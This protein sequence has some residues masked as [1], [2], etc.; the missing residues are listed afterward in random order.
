MKLLYLTWEFP[1]LITGGLGMAC[2]GMVKELLSQGTE[3]DLVL[4]TKEASYFSLKKPEDVDNL[5]SCY[6]NLVHPEKHPKSSSELME[7]IK[8]SFGP[9]ASPAKSKKLKIQKIQKSADI[10]ELMDT[11]N[12]ESSLFQQVRG[13][14]RMAIDVGQRLDYDIIHAHDWLAYP[15]GIL[16]KE[17]TQKPMVAHIHATEFD[18]SGGPGSHRI[19]NIEY[20]GMMAADKVVAVSNLTADLIKE[21]YHI[22]AD[23]I[24][25]VHNAF[26]ITEAPE[27]KK[28]IFKEPMVLFM[29]RITIQKGPDYFLEVAR[30]VLQQNRNVRFVMAGSGDMERHI[31]HKAASMGM[32]TRFLFSG[33]LKRNEVE[34]VLSSADIFMLPSV[35]EPFGIAPL[36]A[37]SYGALAVISKNAGV[38]EI[39]QNAYKIDFWDIDKM[40]NVVLDF[41]ND[42]A[43]FREASIKSR[44]EVMNMKWTEAVKKLTNVFYE[45]EELKKC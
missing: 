12:D 7:L 26:T 10:A 36:E 3:I 16:L 5:A 9:Y 25:I 42:P 44:Q 45:V 2:Y 15:A 41:V 14:T 37:M 19:H 33:F 31:L 22:P 23:R 13:Y 4:P 38:A 35:S 27:E 34:K 29:G 28:K 8:P 18:R 24:R 43:K 30:R 1:P 20:Q 11:L 6:K 21:K 32:G 39:I 40:V 17:I